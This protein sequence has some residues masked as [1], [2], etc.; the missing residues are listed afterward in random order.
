M[1]KPKQRG[2]YISI[3]GP[4]GAGKG[5]QAEL[6]CQ[7]LLSL[8]IKVETFQEPGGSRLGQI[9]RSI[10]KGQPEDPVVQYLFQGEPYELDPHTELSLFNAAR[11]QGLQETVRPHLEAGTWIIA[12][13]S[14]LSSLAY[15]GYGRGLDLDG[16]RASCEFAIQDLRP[17]LLIVLTSPLEQTRQRIEHRGEASDRFESAG[18]DFQHRVHQ[19]YR[20]EAERL[21]IPIIQ[22]SGTIEEVA[23]Q[24]WSY[25]EPLAK[26]AQS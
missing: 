2:R 1:N 15:Q 10:L 14:Y 22:A 21:G 8:G 6:L 18:D 9:L 20:I 3:D 16:A 25:V 11:S 17:D 24:I 23:K 12:D 19:G 7:A 13:R 26:E 4:D 5:T